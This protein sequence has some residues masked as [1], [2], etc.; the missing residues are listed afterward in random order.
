MS[1]YKKALCVAGVAFLFGST[2]LLAVEKSAVDVM[3]KAFQHTGSMDKYTFKAVIL[4]NTTLEDGTPVTYRY[5][6]TVKVDRPAKIR[7]D[8]KGEFLNRSNYI[9]DGLYTI[10]EHGHEYYGQLSVPKDLDKAL[11]NIFKNYDIKAPLSSLVYSDMTNR[12]KFKSSKY[13]GTTT[14]G[15]VECDYVA[16]KNGKREVHAWVTT[17][18][19]PLVKAYTIIDTSTQPHIRINTTISWGKSS[20]VRDS[21]FI[22]KVPKGTSKISVLPAN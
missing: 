18:E 3:T 1:L 22:F 17:G 11:D 16:F 9:N 8:S 12:M 15:G 14:L 13:F 4:E 6:T 20:S 2:H 21:D 5:D 10:I 7:V 19:E